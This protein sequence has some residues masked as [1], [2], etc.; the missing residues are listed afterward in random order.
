M[1]K[2]SY[3]RLALRTVDPNLQEGGDAS[4]GALWAP[5]KNGELSKWRDF[6]KKTRNAQAQQGGWRGKSHQVA[7]S[8]AVISNSHRLC[9]Q[10]K[11]LRA[12]LKMLIL[13]IFFRI[14]ETRLIHHRS[15]SQ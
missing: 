8:V 3:P 15:R 1:Y 10:V 11:S 2:Y 6:Y 14:V 7:E 13:V 12:E 9:P 5:S 4:R